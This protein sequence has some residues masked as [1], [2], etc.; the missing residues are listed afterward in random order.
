MKKGEV[1]S[2]VPA[3]NCLDWAGRGRLGRLVRSL[4]FFLGQGLCLRHGRRGDA[5]GALDGRVPPTS[6]MA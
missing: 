1:M 3:L 5:F 2:I 4:L 6:G